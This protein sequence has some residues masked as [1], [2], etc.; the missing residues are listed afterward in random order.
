MTILLG[1]F[2]AV[3]ICDDVR[4]ENTNKD[5]LIGVYGGHIVVAQF[6]ITLTLALY[7]EYYPVQRGEQEL[8]LKVGVLEQSTS[9]GRVGLSIGEDTPLSIAI[10]GIAIH[11]ERPG[12]LLIDVSN[13]R[14]IW[15]TIKR[16]Q[17]LQGDVKSAISPTMT[18]GPPSGP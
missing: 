1:Q 16:K 5:I 2:G 8:F 4:K 3:L 9:I 6:P 18:S 11:V 14:T 7:L 12:E 17:I 15:T 13:D 10:T